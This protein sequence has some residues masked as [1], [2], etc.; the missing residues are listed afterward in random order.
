MGEKYLVY[1]LMKNKNVKNKLVPQ[2]RFPEF[3]NTEGWVEMPLSNVAKLIT[4]K[5]GG[6]SYTLMSVTAGIGLVSQIEKFGREI[7]GE[8]YKNY[9]VI[10]KGDFAYN[11]S[12]VKLH[13][14][15]QIALLE[16]V[17]M[18]AVPNSI[19]T[20]FSVDQKYVLPYFL[21]YPFANN[22]HGKWLQKFISV[23]ARANGALNVDSKDLLALPILLPSLAE[24]QKIADCLTFLDDLIT[25]ESQK[26]AALKTHKKG[27][28][29]QLF[30]AEGEKVPQ[31]RFKEFQNTEGW[32][33]ING[34][35]VFDTISNKNHN[36]D[37][38]ILAITQEH[39]AVPRDEINYKVIVTDKSVE[40]YKVVEVGDFII[41][42]RSFQGGIEYSDYKGICS[43]AYI[44]LRKKVEIVDSFFK[45]YFKTVSFIQELNKNIEGLRDGKMVSY[46]QFSDLLLPFP[47]PAEQQKIADCLTSLDVL[48]TGQS[49]RLAALKVHKQGLLQQLFPNTNENIEE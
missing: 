31:L 34:N 11:K 2:L 7:A 18:G 20:C 6:K 25:A 47:S 28:M 40:S 4:E 22:I 38:P 9:Y 5:T 44:I 8:A 23:G 46:K 33:Y 43:P 42:L 45:I 41:S 30:P 48:I 32:A 21:K 39:G 17:D 16:N 3:Q 24:Q 36:S 1:Q 29:Q 13:P 10:K 26:L 14:E 27:L 35:D 37:L 12:S 15:G 19:F 49:E